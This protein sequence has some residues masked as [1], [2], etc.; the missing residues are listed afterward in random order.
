MNLPLKR[1]VEKLD[2]GMRLIL[3]E[4][5]GFHRSL[6]M[7]VIPAGALNIQEE[8]DGNRVVHPSGVAHYL[9]HQMFQLNGE[10]VTGAFAAMQAQTNAYTSYERTCYYFTT[11]GA[12]EK[13]LKLLMD[14]V[15]NLEISDKSVNK[16]R[17]IILS[18]YNMYEQDPD[19]RLVREM[20][21]SLFHTF[22]MKLDILGTPEDIE[23]MQVEDLESFYRTYYDPSQVTL[24][25]IGGFDSSRLEDQI[26]ELAVNYPAKLEKTP[27]LVFDQESDELVRENYELE[28]D[29][30]IPYAML[31]VK[32]KPE[33]TLEENDRKDWMLNLWLTGTF[34]GFNP[35]Y[36]DWIRQGILNY[37]ADA[38][39]D[40]NDKY[41]ILLFST[42]TEKPQEFYALCKEIL[43]KREPLSEKTF[44]A[45]KTH[46]IA[47]TLREVDSF[48]ALASQHARWSQGGLDP[49]EEIALLESLEAGQ[50]NDYIRT[51][52]FS[53]ISTVT[54]Y[55]DQ[56]F[57][58][59]LEE[60][61]EEESS[62]SE[63]EENAA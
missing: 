27:S 21:R 47:Q 51:L 60:E 6:F 2:N 29:V 28:M 22:P 13:P 12:Y 25:A 1:T 17:G 33:G 54:I 30:E 7:M 50:V 39:A 15:L 46:Y 19:M 26:K 63:T 4:K 62:M 9:E 38:E 5:P 35:H 37:G 44:Q 53:R 58:D 18:E 16:E 40:L 10:D 45:V 49:L 52:D 31:G 11:N 56:S 59:D 42:Q 24:I 8:T 23:S 43:E 3:L 36:E 32:M 14:F 48:D 20:M 55:P 61:G 34:S 41:A 57:Q